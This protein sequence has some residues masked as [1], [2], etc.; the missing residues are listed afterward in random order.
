MAEVTDETSRHLLSRD[1][2]NS[3]WQLRVDTWSSIADV[4]K[5]LHDA[6]LPQDRRADLEGE[7]GALLD[8]VAPIENYW[9][10]PG[11]QRVGQLRELLVAREYELVS[12]TVEA[13]ARRL[14]G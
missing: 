5:R 1:A 8:L 12:R 6:S 4:T 9:A 10:F 13:I 3:V 11:P 7:L 2:Y 14:V